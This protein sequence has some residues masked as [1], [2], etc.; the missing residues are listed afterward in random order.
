MKNGEQKQDSKFVIKGRVKT[1]NGSVLNPELAG[2]R[3][4]LNP[5]NMEGTLTS[6]MLPLFEKKWKQV[7]AEV[8]GWYTNRT[9]AYK[10]GAI[11]NVAVQ[12]DTWVVN[13][14]CQDEKS[15]YST[16]AAELCLKEVAKLAKAE[17]AS[18]HVSQLF[19]SNFPELQQLLT[20]NLVNKGI[21]VY[22]YLEQ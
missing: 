16:A 2:L 19:F 9:G 1:I 4:V 14:L 22:Y 20:D 21:S 7:K 18:V 12:S 6:P 3:F 13:L 11:N 10:L 15:V 5:V 8:R 17:Q